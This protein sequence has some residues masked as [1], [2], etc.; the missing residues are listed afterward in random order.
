MLRA[1]LHH[2][3]APR[4][5]TT[6]LR[7]HGHVVCL[8]EPM[9][10]IA[11]V[12]GDTID[13]CS[14]TAT[15][16][17]LLTACT[18][19][20]LGQDASFVT[21]LPDSHLAAPVESAAKAAG[22]VLK[23]LYDADPFAGIATLHMPPAG[24]TSSGGSRWTEPVLQGG[25]SSAFMREC[26]GTAF[27]WPTLLRGADVLHTSA[28]TLA[29][30]PGAQDAWK[31]AVAAT[32]MSVAIS[33]AV[34]Q[35]EV[36]CRYQGGEED[37]LERR[38]TWVRNV[39]ALA[40]AGRLS[41]LTVGAHDLDSVCSAFGVHR[42]ESTS[43][44]QLTEQIEALALQLRKLRAASPGGGSFAAG[45]LVVVPV[46]TK[47]TS[48]GGTETSRLT[49][50]V[51]RWS[52]VAIG[53]GGK[54]TELDTIRTLSATTE[55]VPV[56]YS[57]NGNGVGGD[58]AFV[59]GMLSALM[60]QG[61]WH[62]QLG[63]SVEGTLL[64]A[65]SSLSPMKE[66]DLRAA[67]RRGDITAG[68]AALIA[69]GIADS[70]STHGNSTAASVTRNYV[71]QVEQDYK[72]RPATLSF[73]LD[74]QEDASRRSHESDGAGEAAITHGK[75]LLTGSTHLPGFG[76]G[77]DLNAL[78]PLMPGA[79]VSSLGDPFA[80][81]RGFGAVAETVG[82][83]SAGAAGAGLSK[84]LR[85]L[86]KIRASLAAVATSLNVSEQALLNALTNAVPE[87]AKYVPLLSM[88]PG[89]GGGSSI[90]NSSSSSS[91]SSSVFADTRAVPAPKVAPT[92]TATSRLQ[93]KDVA[94][95]QSTS[96]TVLESSQEHDTILLDGGKSGQAPIPHVASADDEMEKVWRTESV[97]HAI[98]RSRM[99]L[100]VA[101]PVDLNRLTELS[102]AGATAVVLT[103][104]PRGRPDCADEL[105]D[106]A[107]T[108]AAVA[109]VVDEGRRLGLC[110]GIE[111]QTTE[112]M[113]AAA[114]A[115]ARF[116]LVTEQAM[117]AEGGGNE[118]I[119]GVSGLL[120][121]A[122]GMVCMRRMPI[123][124]GVRDSAALDRL[125]SQ[126]GVATVLWECGPDAGSSAET[127][128]EVSLMAEIEEFH[129]DYGGTLR[130]IVGC[131]VTTADSIASMA[132]ESASHSASAAV[133]GV[134]PSWLK[135]GSC[136]KSNGGDSATAADAVIS[137]VARLLPQ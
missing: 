24:A 27:C 113:A 25:L 127:S 17:E 20:R 4:H 77:S 75:G 65:S 98:S 73:T 47:S 11:P 85:D 101:M 28:A 1:L 56:K 130:F 122:A 121:S 5:C 38:D 18:V 74:G 132:A 54:A 106:A 29:L 6:V 51:T 23:A 92:T 104:P 35:S 72:D 88:L 59:G 16:S 102:E 62:Q 79:P 97:S 40:E 58:A 9:L 46:V 64:D 31:A 44:A 76:G 3:R 94:G 50:N 37:R 112:E 68:Y 135:A 86:D 49:Q 87:L 55:H 32:D 70:R 60:E 41:L 67:A 52:T 57:G 131:D 80:M 107:A 95:R 129:R 63:H 109:E 14:V 36:R 78:N 48:T 110:V 2:G 93:T 15:G 136:S 105:I 12:G 33:V 26:S 8:G 120:T 133:L 117:W 10:F 66:W 123:I 43:S 82:L 30:G 45:P 89:G 108:A 83:F 19:T 128:S 111:A 126:H 81:L 22:V 7:R 42:S 53:Q 119:E 118:D 116:V 137:A 84:G 114:Q 91:S 100:P 134:Q 39:V 103:S 115:G 69:T 96:S 99:L 13:T 125:V 71:V 21:A 90:P 61:Q 34:D 124:P